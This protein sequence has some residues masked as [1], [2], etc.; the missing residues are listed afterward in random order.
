M[1]VLRT[2]RERPPA[3]TDYLLT[4][5]A[6]ISQEDRRRIHR[7]IAR[8][9]K[10]AKGLS[11][12]ADL[13]FIVRADGRRRNWVGG[14]GGGTG[15]EIA[16]GRKR[17]PD[18]RQ[19]ELNFFEGFNTSDWVFSIRVHESPKVTLTVIRFERLLLRIHDPRIVNVAAC[20]YRHFLQPIETPARWRYHLTNPI[21]RNGED[22]IGRNHRH[23]FLSPACEIGN[24]HV[25]PNALPVRQNPPST[26]ASETELKRRNKKCPQC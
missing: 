22:V 17:A 20:I 23:S 26:S 25:L 5:A 11:R 8:K 19:V 15:K 14:C 2:P 4:T 1:L 6:T 9:E 13:V 21:R 10:A 18:Q 3:P 16:L 24:E 12:D 7:R